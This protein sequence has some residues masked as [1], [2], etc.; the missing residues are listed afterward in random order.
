MADVR[1]SPQAVNDL[2]EIK[3]YISDELCD[4]IAAERIV[5]KIIND[6]SLLEIS[7]FMGP[8]LSALTHIKSDYRYL[9]CGKYIVFYKVEE[10][11][12]S[13]YRILY[14]ARDY[15]KVLFGEI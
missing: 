12:V 6:Y 10:S 5:K 9:V 14:G 3:A 11:F 13:I 1:L 4:P 15:L 8:E 7:P 2:T